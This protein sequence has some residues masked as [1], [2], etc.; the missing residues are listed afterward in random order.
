MLSEAFSMKNILKTSQ[1]AIS[2]TVN[3]VL[4]KP[5]FAL[6]KPFAIQIRAFVVA[7]VTSGTAGI[8]RKVKEAISYL[9]ATCAAKI[10]S[11][12]GHFIPLAL[13]ESLFE[14]VVIKL[15]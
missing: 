15:T 1:S 8:W 11:W 9:M 14:Q 4:N 2:I 7:A 5:Q 12:I 6:F 13:I 3:S 10:R